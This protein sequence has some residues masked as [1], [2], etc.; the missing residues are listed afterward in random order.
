MLSG[1]GRWTLCGRHR[2]Q[3]GH[4]SAGGEAWLHCD[5]GRRAVVPQTESRHHTRP[6]GHWGLFMFI[7]IQSI[8]FLLSFLTS[9]LFFSL[10][11][12]QCWCTM[13]TKLCWKQ[14]SPTYPHCGYT[15]ILVS[16]GTNDCSTITWMAL[17]RCDL[18]YGSNDCM[19]SPTM[20]AY[21]QTNHIYT[22]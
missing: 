3:A 14:K 11:H 4:P 9:A 5:A 1:H 15:K 18:N 10:L 12:R 19:Q 20:A 7:Q 13:R 6:E 2:V 22:N 21:Q 17:M 8:D 16:Y